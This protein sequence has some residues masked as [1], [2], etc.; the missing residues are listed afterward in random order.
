M[1]RAKNAAAKKCLISP[2]GPL[3]KT[4]PRPHF[5]LIKDKRTHLEEITLLSMALL[6]N[7]AL[8]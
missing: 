8:S 6:K 2:E 1:T 4:V 7:D 5:S 3:T